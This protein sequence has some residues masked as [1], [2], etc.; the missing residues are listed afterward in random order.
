LRDTDER[1]LLVRL[2]EVLQRFP[3]EQPV[4]H[5]QQVSQAPRQPQG[6]GKD[7]CPLHQTAMRQTTKEGRSWF[8]HKIDGRWCK[9]K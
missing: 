6:R 9:G 3:V 8:S 7:W 4:V 5:A 2:E 1:R